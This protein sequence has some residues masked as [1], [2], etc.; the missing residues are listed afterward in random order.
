MRSQILAWLPAALVMLGSGVVGWI[1]G[2]TA[3]MHARADEEV[4]DMYRGLEAAPQVVRPSDLEP[5]PPPVQHWLR[6]SGVV[7]LPLACSVRLRQSGELHTSNDGAWIPIE[8]EQYFTTADPA[9]VWWMEGRMGKVLPLV[10]RDKYVGGHGEMHVAA[11]GIVDV[12]LGRGPKIDQGALLRWLA[13]IIWFPS[14]ALR[15]CVAWE[16][17]SDLRARATVRSHGQS[18]SAVF[19]FDAEGRAVAFD[20]QR[21]F[22]ADGDLEHWAGRNTEWKTVRGVEIPTRGEVTWHLKTGDFT[23]FRWQIDDVET[24]RPFP[25]RDEG[26]RP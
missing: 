2:A 15:G 3:K 21:Y 23:F 7:G 14:A 26:A 11:A 18:A 22:G 4:R 6:R 12:A 24:D 8:A 5:L 13:E 17:I 1:A 16:P 25:F 19:T 9:F 20:A 10:G